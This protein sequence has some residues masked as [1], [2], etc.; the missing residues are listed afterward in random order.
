VIWIVVERPADIH[1]GG[2]YTTSKK[3]LTVSSIGNILN[4]LKDKE[5]FVTKIVW[6]YVFPGSK[7]SNTILSGFDMKA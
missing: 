6:T 7:S 2:V 5:T 3:S 4:E 1:P